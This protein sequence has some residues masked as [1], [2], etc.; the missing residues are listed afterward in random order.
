MTSVL[1]LRQLIVAIVIVLLSSCAITNPYIQPDA[2]DSPK[3]SENGVIQFVDAVEY[4]RT[5]RGIYRAKLV[6]HTKFANHTG[7]GLISLAGL[8]LGLAAFDVDSD[9]ILIPALAGGTG[10]TFA[11]R[12]SSNTRELVYIAGME[13]TTCAVD[14]MLP[15]FFTPGQSTALSKNVDKL[16]NS[17]TKV[18]DDIRSVRALIATAERNT[19][20][21][22]LSILQNARAEVTKVEKLIETADAT[23]V[24]GSG[25]LRSID[26]SGMTLVAAVDAITVEVNKAIQQTQPRIEALADII[27]QLSSATEFFAPGLGI[28]SQ[29]SG[30]FEEGPEPQSGDINQKKMKQ[31]I[32]ALH[33]AVYELT[34]SALELSSA[35]RTVNGIVNDV[36][37]KKPISTLKKCGVIISDVETDIRVLPT[38]IKAIQGAEVEHSIFVEGG[39]KNYVARFLTNPTPGVEVISPHSGDSVIRVKFTK[40]SIPSTYTL[41]VEDSAEHRK[42]V[43]VTVMAKTDNNGQTGDINSVYEEFA[44]FISNQ[45]VTI[46]DKTYKVTADSDNSEVVVNLVS[47][48]GQPPSTD[49]ISCKD[50]R[51]AILKIEKAGKRADAFGVDKEK[52]SVEGVKNC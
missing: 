47:D 1:I 41:L 14:A 18:S 37:Q 8:I 27:S 32:A 12:L 23:Y 20:G 42:T 17:I 19:G 15:L 31:K 48:E 16:S 36:N 52:I 7:S 46:S 22:Q 35:T 39:K 10:Y 21:Q 51:K 30:L 28:S 40:D 43:K 13:A 50:V 25:L 2:D 6:A 4:A 34:S 24:A 45:S 49:E 9:V 26:Q 11:S 3:V 44:T 5:I 33:M 38:E 29:L